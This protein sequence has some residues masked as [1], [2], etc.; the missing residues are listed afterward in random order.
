MAC[1]RCVKESCREELRS[2]WRQV[3]ND[4]KRQFATGS[5]ALAG[6]AVGW[7]VTGLL[8]GLVG[9]FLGGCVGGILGM[10]RYKDGIGVLAGAKPMTRRGLPR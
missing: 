7:A 1:S 3:S 10:A 5:V 2:F 6:S 8:G 4:D 9:M